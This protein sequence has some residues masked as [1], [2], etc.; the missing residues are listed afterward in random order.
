MY[1]RRGQTPSR[2]FDHGKSL[3]RPFDEGITL[4]S[5]GI[6]QTLVWWVGS[7]CPQPYK[8]IIF[9]DFAGDISPLNLVSF[10]MALSSSVNGYSLTGLYQN[11]RKNGGSLLNTLWL[12]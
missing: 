6:L 2:K 5:R 3:H 8:R 9:R 4:K 7:L 12:S 1:F 11:V 10:V